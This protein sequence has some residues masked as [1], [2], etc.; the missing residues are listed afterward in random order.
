MR[1]FL[2]LLVLGWGALAEAQ[3][4]TTGATY[5]SVTVTSSTAGV[6]ACSTV[7]YGC[8]V[9]VPSTAA[10][11]LWLALVNDGTSCAAG[12]TSNKGIRITAGNTYVCAPSEPGGYCFGWG[13]QV[14]LIL[15]SGST[16]VTPSVTSR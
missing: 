1:V 16:S 7:S 8:S 15:E 6:V 12:L 3:L 10:V 2:L 9:T 4:L 13:G 11:P 5:P 14:C